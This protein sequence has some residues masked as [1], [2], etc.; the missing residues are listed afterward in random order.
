MECKTASAVG[1]GGMIG[2]Q[3]VAGNKDAVTAH[4]TIAPTPIDMVNVPLQQATLTDRVI[5]SRLVGGL[6][7]LPVSSPTDPG[8]TIVDICMTPSWT[9]LGIHHHGA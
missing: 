5:T 9:G 4:P 7:L 6:G 8:K 2:C 3:A 1:T